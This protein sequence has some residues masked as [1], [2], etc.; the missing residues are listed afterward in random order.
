MRTSLSLSL[1]FIFG[2][3]VVANAE[4]SKA[5]SVEEMTASI[6]KGFVVLDDDKDGKL[7]LL[8]LIKAVR[9]LG[10]GA[11]TEETQSASASRGRGGNRGGGRGQ[12]GQER[13]SQA[14]GGRGQSPAEAGTPSAGGQRGQRGGG[15]RGGGMA[16]EEGGNRGGGNRGGAA[17]G[18][19]GGRGG[20]DPA[21]R[22]KS[23]DQDGDG[24]LKGDEINARLSG[25]KFAEDGQV[26]L[27]EFQAAFEEMRSQ[28]AAGGG[29]SHGGGGHSHGGGGGGRGGSAAT[30]SA[31]AVL[32]VAFDID[33]DRQVTL[34]EVKEALQKEVD[35]QVAEGL[36]LD[37]DNDGRITK[38]EFATQV[39]A[40]EGT[41][42]DDD[43]FDRRTR[44]MFGRQ[45]TDQDGAISKQEITHQVLQQSSLRAN[46]LGY[47]LLLAN[48]DANE[49]GKISAEELSKA[50]DADM[51][52]LLDISAEEP[53]PASAFYGTV[54]R[55]LARR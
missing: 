12:G 44:M 36:K 3:A 43:G 39:E 5:P 41:Q 15:N 26:S 7:P 50:A 24:L 48:V 2:S 49:D 11:K 4:E 25:S 6:E 29:H 33:R 18:G 47:C 19:G 22:F 10:F 37:A 32:L 13:G 23:F 1:A 14:R 27:E 42:L 31:D 34:D 35:R 45:D 28:M 51:V 17:R 55:R 53:L 40:E 16:S 8:S 21:E 30:T 20:F 46:A 54:R 52:E 9:P 38:A